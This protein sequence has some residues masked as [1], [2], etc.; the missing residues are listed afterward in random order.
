MADRDR[1]SRVGLLATVGVVLLAVLTVGVV[2]VSRDRVG[3]A[4]EAASG[5]PPEPARLAEVWRV[6][7]V[8]AEPLGTWAHDTVLTRI[9]TRD[10][11]GGV[12]AYDTTDGSTLWRAAPPSGAERPC[13]ASERTNRQGLGAVLYEGERGC[14]VLAV[15]DGDGVAWSTELAG[16]PENGQAGGD[17]QGGRSGGDGGPE[18]AG[19]AEQ[20]ALVVG[21][22]TVTVSLDNASGEVAA[23]HRLDLATGDE[24]PLPEP[25]PGECRD[26]GD[27]RSLRHA[28]GRVVAVHACARTRVMSVY[29]AD[30][31]ELQWTRQAPRGVA[32]AATR[33][34]AG[35]PVLLLRG[36]GA[37]RHVVAYGE[38][39]EELWR[40]PA[41]GATGELLPGSATVADD[42][43]LSRYATHAAADGVGYA[44]YGLAD[45]EQRWSTRL[46]AETRLYGIDS[47]GMPL[48][49]HPDGDRLRL[50][51]LDPAD[52]A[53]HPAGAVPAP[54]GVEVAA[55]T[56][57]DDQLYVSTRT[58][59]DRLRLRAFER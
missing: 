12:V 24:L 6:P 36:E 52:G 14:T 2:G 30:S 38:T 42:V 47:N 45:G 34:L 25:P 15:V 58:P 18:A 40:R 13:A 59:D 27:P 28:D 11:N 43:L 29:D 50:L 8:A 57:D 31:G 21:E 4:A 41:G 39:G 48:L 37:E 17:G 55:I 7:T 23:F 20:P 1:D 35:D 33:L 32:A 26:G 9:T 44:A 49:G 54:D 46:P 22:E 3:D 53:H 19:G 51:W 56:H 10:G 5:P 16:T